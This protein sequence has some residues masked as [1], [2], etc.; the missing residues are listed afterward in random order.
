MRQFEWHT[1]FCS[2]IFI[3]A[4]CSMQ[5]WTQNLLNTKQES[6]PVKHNIP[7]FTTLFTAVIIWYTGISS[8]KL[9]HMVF[10]ALSS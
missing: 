9:G 4:Y 7:S 5:M 1:K 3:T 8:V 6:Y 2:G 10:E